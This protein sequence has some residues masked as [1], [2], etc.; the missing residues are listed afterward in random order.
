MKTAEHQTLS[1]TL[2]CSTDLTFGGRQLDFGLLAD[3]WS[4]GIS[5]VFA[6]SDPL[7]S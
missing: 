4:S 7:P 3:V 6:R 5:S 2:P 1:A